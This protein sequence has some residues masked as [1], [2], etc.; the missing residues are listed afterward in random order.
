M[1]Y[2]NWDQSFSVG[3]KTLDNQH[4]HLFAII[5]QLYDAYESKKSI[6][7]IA[8]IFDQVLEYTLAHFSIEEQYMLH[9]RYDDYNEHKAL[10]QNLAAKAKELAEKIHDGDLEAV[11]QAHLF[12]KGWLEKHIKKVD[13]QYA[14]HIRATKAQKD[15]IA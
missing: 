15:K 7:V 12:L 5:N 6:E 2:I 4:K 11:V 10:H 13:L 9:Y 3:V 8:E 14:E 1:S